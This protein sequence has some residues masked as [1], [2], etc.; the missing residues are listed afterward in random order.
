MRNS[1]Q[2]SY[3]LDLRNLQA[4][5]PIFKE[6]IFFSSIAEVRIHLCIVTRLHSSSSRVHSEKLPGSQLVKKFTTFYSTQKFITAVTSARHLSL[7]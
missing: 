2:N 5:L 3:K 4:F 1:F 6:H 7:S